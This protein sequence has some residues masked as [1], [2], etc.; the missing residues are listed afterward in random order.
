[1]RRA[2]A[3]APLLS[4]VTNASHLSA[5]R[6]ANSPTSPESGQA[7]IRIR[8]LKIDG[9]DPVWYVSSQQTLRTGVP[10]D[11]LDDRNPDVLAVP[12][13]RHA[14]SVCVSMASRISAAS[15]L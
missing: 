2:F 3:S 6:K 14:A 4:G 1:M 10:H 7:Q 9:A 12:N 5:L 11:R 15:A 8:N 13:Q